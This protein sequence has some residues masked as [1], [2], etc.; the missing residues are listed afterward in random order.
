MRYFATL[1]K[2][3]FSSSLILAGSLSLLAGVGLI[4]PVMAATPNTAPREL[5]QVV[6]Q[7]EDAA[8]RQDIEAVMQFYSPNFS[9][10]DTLSRYLYQK[11]LSEFWQAYSNLNYRTEL[12]FWEREG[13]ALVAETLTTITGTREQNGRQMR[14]ETQ[15]RSRQ[16]F[17]NQQVVSQEILSERT[18]ITAGENPPEVTINLPDTVKVGDRFSFD[19]IV[20]QP[21]N[22][23]DVLLGAAL[24]ERVGSDRF[25]N[26]TNFDLE[27]LP[28]GGLYKIGTAPLLPDNRWVSAVLIRGDGMTMIT[29][30]LRVVD[31]D[32][33][34]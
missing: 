1:H 31:S 24:E 10:G 25:F 34:D 32:D 2:R 5:K 26:P 18:E 12:L 22:N 23:D 14:M 11:G 27:L 20:E 17:E 8:N 7:I 13:N 9:S 19:A 21:L 3:L 28:A 15:L 29:Q 16:R 30:R 33:Q 4:T 6:E